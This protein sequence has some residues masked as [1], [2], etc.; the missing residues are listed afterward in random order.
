MDHSY[1]IH[2]VV[3]YFFIAQIQFADVVLDSHYSGVNTDFSTFYGNFP[4]IDLCNLYPVDL[5]IVIGSTDSILAL[6]TGSYITLGFT[7]NLI[8][9][10]E[11]QDDLFIVES[12]GGRE[13]AELWV[14][15]NGI[16]FTFLTIMDGGTGNSID[17]NDFNYSGNVK[18]VKIVGLDSGGCSPGFDLASIFGLEGANCPCGSAL[19]PFP[20]DLCPIDSNF[21]LSELVIDNTQGKWVGNT[22]EDNRFNPMGLS[23]DYSLQFLVNFGHPVCPIDTID[24]SITIPSCDCNELVGGNAIIDSCGICNVPNDINFSQSCKDCLGIPNGDALL[25]DC[26]ICLSQKDPLFNKTC[27]DCAGTPDGLYLI[28]LCGEC[29]DPAD[30]LFDMTCPEKQNFYIPNV[31]S[32]LSGDGNELFQLKVNPGN[33]V[34]I[35]SL[36]IYD[37]WGNE[38]YNVTNESIVN[39]QNW[40]DGRKNNKLLNSGVYAYVL[41]VIYPDSER[42][43]FVGSISMLY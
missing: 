27:V 38:V 19:K 22:V 16:D 28:D 23:G 37:K 15:E 6:P 5:S 43:L 2:F 9:D 42:E 4:P 3:L 25:D 10:A 26:G 40:W 39:V 20:T 11:D 13:L 24:Y 36:S 34:I 33:L 18:A 32:P 30:P 8:F 41:H 1:N 12:G 29:L 21:I 35:E 31:F 14:S 7:D 17:L